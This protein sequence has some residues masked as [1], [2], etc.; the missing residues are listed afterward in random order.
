EKHEAAA[1]QW[2]ELTPKGEPL[3]RSQPNIRAFLDYAGVALSYDQMAHRKIITRNGHSRTLDDEVARDL[4][5]EA[6]M[7]GLKSGE[8]YFTAVLESLS[9]CSGF[10]PLKDY[11][12]SLQWDGVKRLD[13]WL[14]TYLG[15]EDTEL[16]TIYGRKHLIA[17]VRRI[18]QP[19]AKYDTMLVLQGRQGRGKSSAVR[20][21]CPSE[22]Y[23]TDNLG[24]GA[25]QKAIIEVTTGKW[26]VELAELDGMGK[27]DASTV[28]AMISRQVDGARLA[29][30]RSST[31]RPRQ[32]VLIG[33]CNDSQY[34][35]DTTGNRR[36]WPVTIGDAYDPDE[37]VTR[38]IQDRDQLWAEAAHFEA[39]GE[40]LVLPK[41][42]WEVAAE[43]Q[44]ERLI[45]DPWQERLTEVLHDRTGFIS[46]DE[47]YE[48]LGVVTERRNTGV[49]Q[50]IAGILTAMGFCRVQ[51]RGN[52]GK[53]QWG[54]ERI[55]G[56]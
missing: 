35:R 24:V 34:L 18:R 22:D 15:V 14:H 5:L 52:G 7:L 27:R 4:W 42:L 32:F 31:E 46:S 33:T 41:H 54:Y 13:K 56:R 23:F 51:R 9:R 6:D 40:N 16:N 11:L 10:H 8:A 45:I 50:R 36:F 28:K 47:I 19:G 37:A 12:D 20:A 38:L 3:G 17:A 30:G 48:A 2:P 43:G 26:L 1:F 21:L 25:D 39:Q 55:A 44:A 29:Y 53:R 49:S